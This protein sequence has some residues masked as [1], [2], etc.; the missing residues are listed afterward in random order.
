MLLLRCAVRRCAVCGVRCAV[1]RCIISYSIDSSRICIPCVLQRLCGLSSICVH[2]LNK[3]FLQVFS[4]LPEVPVS[5]F[6]M[7]IVPR[8]G[9]QV[10][11]FLFRS[12]RI[13]VRVCQYLLCVV[14]LYYI[15]LLSIF[16]LVIPDP[17]FICR[18][19]LNNNL[20]RYPTTDSWCGNWFVRCSLIYC[21]SG[22]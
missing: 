1:R 19:P 9:F 15:I 17:R 11:L 12:L 8:E 13:V 5:S 3:W 20:S 10:G 16:I 14:L 22:V 18:E 21:A 4:F 7:M 2:I 6:S